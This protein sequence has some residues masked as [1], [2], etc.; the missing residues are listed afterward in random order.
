VRGAAELS[1]CDEDLPFAKI[2]TATNVSIRCRNLERAEDALR[3][4]H[5]NIE[6]AALASNALMCEDQAHRNLTTT[7][8]TQECGEIDTRGKHDGFMI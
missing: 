8:Q 7:F 5:R 3:R 6:R 4:R 2:A 1:R